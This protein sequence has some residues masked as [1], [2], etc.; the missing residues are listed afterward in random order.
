[1]FR[2][3]IKQLSDE[4]LM[5]EVINHH[6]HAALNELHFRY[7]K[8]LLGYFIKMLNRDENLAQDFV[9]DLFL[10]ILEKKQLYNPDKK[11]YTWVFTIASNM[12][13]SSYRRSPMS[14]LTENLAEERASSCTQ[15]N[16]SDKDGFRMLLEESIAKLEHH[17]KT[18][19]V[20]RYMEEFS[21]QE[22]ADIT[23]VSVGTVKSRLFYATK[24]MMVMLKEYDPRYESN[25]FKL[26]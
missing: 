16:L 11:F 9:Q 17:H 26:E 24:S 25:Y 12:C 10:K 1:M 7:S 15:E 18:A 20:L 22:I 2:K 23:L 4:E 13:K 8:K 21:L 3:Q 14:S 5:V 6:S 19:F